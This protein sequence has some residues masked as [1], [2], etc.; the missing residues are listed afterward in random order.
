M[1]LDRATLALLHRLDPERAHGLTLAALRSGL[2][3]GRRVVA[4][5]LLAQ[6]IWGRHFASPVGLAAGFDKNAVAMKAL[7][8]L[9]FGFVEVG[10]LTPRA[11]AGSAR[12]RIFRLPEDGGVINRLGFNNEGH[13]AAKARLAV[14]RARESGIVGVNLGKNR[15]TEDAAA[16][17]AQ[18]VASLGALADYLVIN[19]SSPNTPGLRALQGR[20][21][22]E[23]LLAPVMAARDALPAGK[24]PPLVLKVAPDLEAADKEDIAQVALAAGLDGLAV[25][26]T[27]IARP[28]ALRARHRGETGGLSGRPLFQLSTEVLGD[29]YRLTGARIPLIGI[30]GVETAAAAYAKIRAGASLVQLYTGLVYGGPGL[31]AEITGGLA[32]LLREDGFSGIGAAIGCDHRSP[33][34]PGPVAAAP[35]DPS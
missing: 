14:F 7:L 4:D 12:P 3:P 22:L 11:Q 27:T 21:E 29:F 34:C 35:Q 8:G 16:D 2:L 31:V 26:N 1:F 5:P 25:S 13:A 19:V 6:E 9:G 33:G 20:G 17:Y 18:G 23:A 10:S 30:G 32:A 28:E 15:E 24:R